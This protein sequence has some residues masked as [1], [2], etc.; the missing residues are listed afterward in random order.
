MMK[1]SLMVCTAF[2]LLFGGCNGKRVSPV[3]PNVYQGAG[4]PTVVL[5]E[6]MRH[7]TGPDQESLPG[8]YAGPICPI[9]NS[10]VSISVVNDVYVSAVDD[11]PIDLC[12]LNRE[13]LRGARGGW[14]LQEGDQVSLN[15]KYY[16][17]SFSF[18]NLESEKPGVDI[19]KKYLADLGYTATGPGFIVYRVGRNV[20]P[21]IRFKI[22]YLYNLEKLPPTVERTEDSLKAFMREQFGERVSIS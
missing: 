12:I 4:C 8:Q 14:V 3:D 18:V 22:V 7:V 6:D 9:F 19:F 1:M 2:L 16:H 11:V 10:D 20:G 17:E 13:T 15:G 5:A 21:R